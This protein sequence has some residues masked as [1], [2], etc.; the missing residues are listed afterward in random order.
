MRSCL[1]LI[2]TSVLA[3]STAAQALDVKHSVI[4]S[5]GGSSSATIGPRTIT[6][7][8]T[9]GQGFAG[10]TSTSPTP[11]TLQLSVRGGFWGSEQLLPTAT[12]VS[13]AGRVTTAQGRGI[14]MALVSL[15]NSTG[16]TRA[17]ITNVFGYYRFDVV[18]VGETYILAVSAKRFQFTPRVLV[19]DDEISDF[20]FVALLTD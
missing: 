8:G 15:T 17:V 12:T 4:A 6:V 13:V 11:P 10:T 14:A 3:A 19:V 9:I 18:P 5:G 2:F 16:K 20:D 7:E 1:V